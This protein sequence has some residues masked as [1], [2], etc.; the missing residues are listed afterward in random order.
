MNWHRLFGLIPGDFFSGSPYVV[1]LEKD[2]AL[3]KQLLDVLVLRRGQGRF[4][5]RLPD[6]LEPLAP[7][8]LMAFRFHHDALTDWILKEITGD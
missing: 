2:L 6:G 5:G 8:N 4:R 1:D 7:H 3:Q